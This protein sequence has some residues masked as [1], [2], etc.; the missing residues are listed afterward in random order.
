M[1]V[2]KRPIAVFALSMLVPLVA[3]TPDETPIGPAVEEVSGTLELAG[4]LVGGGTL[5]AADYAGRVVV[6][7]V[8]ATWCAPCRREQP[9]LAAAAAE[10]GD[11]GAMF[12]GVDFI[13][14]QGAAL[15][16]QDEF[17]VPYPSVFDRSGHAAFALGVPFLPTTIF[18]DAD[19]RLRY[20]VTGEIDAATL[21]KLLAE[22][23]A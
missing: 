11:D 23:S 10:Q 17:D 6:V 22:V 1:A 16:W 18:A 19:G 3:C 13:D 8:W 4:P 20:R 12:V 2:V 9:V 15:D 7:N 21:D 5:T 14:D